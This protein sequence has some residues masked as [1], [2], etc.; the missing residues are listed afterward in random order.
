MDRNKALEVWE[1]EFG[2]QEYAYD[3]TGRKIKK[4]DYLIKNQV[5]WVVSYMC[6][7][8]LGGTTDD[9]NTIILHHLT[10]DEKQDNYPEFSVDCINYTVCH[11]KD[12]NFYYIVKTEHRIDEI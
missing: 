6:P 10:A 1:H 11:E 3:F 7:I 4:D 2:N 5:G 9:G 8:A 12:G